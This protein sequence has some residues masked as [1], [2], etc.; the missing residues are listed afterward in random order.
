MSESST[1]L[2]KVYQALDNILNQAAVKGTCSQKSL[3]IPFA[4]LAESIG[5]K[6]SKSQSQQVL[7]LDIT[8]YWEN[9]EDDLG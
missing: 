1:E 4:L 8:S 7:V 3:Y 6:V 9:A 5:R 2:Q